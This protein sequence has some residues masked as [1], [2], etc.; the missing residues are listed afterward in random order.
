MLTQ[1]RSK[2]RRERERVCIKSSEEVCDP[3]KFYNWNP[4]CHLRSKERNKKLGKKLQ[5][6]GILQRKIRVLEK[7]KIDRVVSGKND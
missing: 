7:T 6:S 4:N 5:R 1:K 2:Q 3:K